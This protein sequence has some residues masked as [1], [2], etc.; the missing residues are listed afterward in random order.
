MAITKVSRGLLNTGI[1]D[2][3]NATAITI[4]SD[5][6]VILEKN[7][8]LLGGVDQRIQISTSGSGSSPDTGDNNIHIRGNDDTLIFNAAGNGNI[9]FQEQGT[10]R[11]RIATS[12]GRVGI[13]TSSPGTIFHTRTQNGTSDHNSGAGMHVFDSSTAGNR[14]VNVWLD[15]DG[16]N[17]STTSDGAYAYLEKVGGGGVFRII[18]QDSSDTEFW[19]GGSKKAAINSSSELQFNSGFGS[20]G[21]AYGVRAWVR[22]KGNT[23]GTGNRQ[24]NG[25]GNVST[26]GYIAAGRYRVNFTNS[27]PDVY[28]AVSATAIGVANHNPQSASIDINNSNSTSYIDVAYG[29]SGGASSV[30]ISND[31]GAEYNAIIVR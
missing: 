2:S 9:L 4:D 18:N 24:V 25:S 15:A 27:M 21:T 28:Y 17:F 13:G 19:V 22:F 23:S 31:G 8:H 3:S 26:V 6:R 11:M 7:L 16:G 20:V 5:E 29:P 12:T 30:S 1:S 14:I 10:E